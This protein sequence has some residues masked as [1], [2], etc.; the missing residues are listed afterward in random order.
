MCKNEDLTVEKFSCNMLF[1]AAGPRP[2]LWVK[3]V[4]REARP[5][6]RLVNPHLPDFLPPSPTLPRRACG[7]VK[8][9][10]LERSRPRLTPPSLLP[11]LCPPS[12]SSSLRT[13]FPL[14][15][16]VPRKLR[17]VQFGFQREAREPCN[18]LAPL[19]ATHLNFVSSCC[20]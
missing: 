9:R 13:P 19:A 1:M 7:A 20:G 4:P 5:R 14:P 15:L 18:L 12:R 8:T 11:P 10:P 6:T 3:T 2:R 16:A 17:L